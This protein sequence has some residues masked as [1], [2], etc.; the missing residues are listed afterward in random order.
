MMKKLEEEYLKKTNRYDIER[1]MLFNIQKN[2]LKELISDKLKEEKFYKD[3]LV[4]YMK[5]LINKP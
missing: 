4:K 5:K 2:D 3:L 1:Q